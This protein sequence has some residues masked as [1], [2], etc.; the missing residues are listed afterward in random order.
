MIQAEDNLIITHGLHIFHAGFQYFRQRIDTFYAGNYGRSGIINFDGQFTAGPAATASASAAS[1]FPEAD[2]WLG[3]PEAVQRGVDTG[4][5]GQ[6]SNVFAAYVQDDWRATDTLTVNLGLRYETH[7]P[8]IEVHDRQANFGP[9]SGTEYF[10][11]QGSCPYSNCR[12]LYNSYN[13]GFDFQPRLGFAWTPSRFGKTTVIRGAYTVSSYL[14]GTGTNLRLPLNPPFAEEH[15]TLYDAFTFPKST[16]DQG[17][18]VLTAPSDP[19]AN[20]VDFTGKGILTC[21]SPYLSG[22]PALANISQISGTESNSDMMYHALQATLQKRFSQGLQYQVAYTYSKCMTNSIG[23]YGSWGGQ[24]VPTAA[25]WQN[26]Y[27]SHSEWAPCIN[28]V[29]HLLSTYAVY[30]LPFGRGKKFGSNWNSATRGV[31]GNW[32][33]SGILQLRGGFP[34]TVFASDNSGTG[35][36]TQRANCLAPPKY[37]KSNVSASDGGGIQWLDGSSYG[38]Q[39]VGSFGTCGVGT[40]RGPGLRTFDLSL[41]KDFPISES[42]RLEFRSEFINFTNTPILNAPG[43]WIGGGFGQIQG[44]QGA[45]NIQFGLKLYY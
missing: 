38:P 19:F 35:E 9:I 34:S 16:T 21:A 32:Q 20:A 12:A 37:P 33:V 24:V 1:G 31:L 25:Y 18:T 40:F 28:D 22:N 7:T 29:T 39:D 41:Q 5:W 11:G 44:S 30:E 10:A 27:D 17:F 13:G 26:L 14:E 2:F 36:R 15:N 6:R 8:W 42:K 45:R 23:Y 3:L 4:T 43:V